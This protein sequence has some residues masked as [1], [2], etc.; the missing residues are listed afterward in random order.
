[1]KK[2]RMIFAALSLA[3]A[4][5]GTPRLNAD[6]MDKDGKGGGHDGMM[7]E[8]L[9]LTDEQVAKFKDARKANREAMQPLMEKMKTDVDS[10]RV[11]VDKK[12]SDKDLSAQLDALKADKQAVE[13]Q[14]KKQM[15]DMAAVLTPLQKAKFVISMAD[16]MHR[17]MGGRGGWNHGDKGDKGDK[18]GPEDKGGDK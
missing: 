9:G 5:W 17:G 6:P 11:L 16:R 15:E 7:K 1:M 14:Q 3:V 2:S 12:A 4:V 13:D 10:L 18:G 8:K